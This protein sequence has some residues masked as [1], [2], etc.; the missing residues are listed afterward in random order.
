MPVFLRWLLR[1]GPMNPIAVRLVQNGSRRAKHNYVRSG[2]LAVLILVLLWAM[3]GNTP[4]GEVSYRELASAGATSFAWIAYLQVGLICVLAPVFMAGAIAQEANPRTWDILLTTPMSKLEIVLGNFLGRLFFVLALL[5]ASL[6]LFALTQFFGGVPGRSILASYAVSAGAA[7]L[8]GAIAIGLSV[9]RLVGQRAVFAFYVCVVTYLAATIAIDAW[10]RASGYGVAGGAG[11]TWLSALNPF[12]ALRA[13]L[14]PAA[15]PAATPG[16]FTGLKALMLESPARAWTLGSLALSALLVLVS[17]ATVRAGGLRRSVARPRRRKVVGEPDA[18]GVEHRAPREVWKNP[19]AWREAAARNATFWRIMGR[20]S[21]VVLGSLGA[22]A[23]LIAYH[24]G[25]MGADEFRF[26]LRSVVFTEVFVI[27]LVA[28]NMAAT[29]VAGER[30][31]GTLDLLLTTPITPR[32][33]LT[34]K[35]RGLVSYLMPL[36]AVPIVTVGLPGLYVLAGALGKPDRATIAVTTLSGASLDVP[37]VL[38]ESALIAAL[39]LIPFIAFCVMIGLQW[40][41]KSKGT[42]GAVV[43]TVA[44]VFIVSGILGLCGWASGA[45]M[46]VVGPVLAALSPASVLD[47]LVAPRDA[48]RGDRRLGRARN[49]PDRTG[50]GRGRVPARLLRDR[51]HH[52]LGLGAQLRLH[53]PQARRVE[54]TRG[55]ISPGRSAQEAKRHRVA[56]ELAPVGGHR[57]L[58]H[59]HEPEHK[60]HKHER[61]PHAAG[62]NPD[63]DGEDCEQDRVDDQRDLEVDRLAPVVVDEGEPSFLTPHMITGMNTAMNDINRCASRDRCMKTAYVRSSPGAPGS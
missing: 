29:A 23:L 27:A 16:T 3:L 25:S 44:I 2:Y 7:V 39:V 9:S 22:V 50:H 15:Y 51:L 4:T 43:G 61:E 18:D 45:D 48:P 14:S 33:Y 34:G 49:G 55:T 57:R 10:L 32:D 19:I 11:V 59:A 20:W 13:L 12:L 60:G 42:L 63:R 41:L 30:E 24:A 8:V 35:L 36:I 6:P 5:F 40:S 26:I 54:L 31:D 1:L 56:V 21:F 46:P 38:P 58:D 52:R 53:G 37:V 62:Q 17:T 47:A 28:M